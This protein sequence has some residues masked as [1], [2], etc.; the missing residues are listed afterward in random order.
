MRSLPRVGSRCA[1]AL[2]LGLAAAEARSY[3]ILR[4][5]DEDGDP[6]TINE[7]TLQTAAVGRMILRPTEPGEI[8]AGATFDLGRSCLE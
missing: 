8:F 4:D 2:L 6:D 7:S 3:E 1:L 5:I